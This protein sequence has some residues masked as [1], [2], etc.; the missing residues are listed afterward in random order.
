[1]NERTDEYLTEQGESNLSIEKK[2]N[3]TVQEAVEYSGIGRN[4][5]Y[6]LLKNPDCIFRLC[7]G[8]K[9]LVKRKQFEKYLETANA[10]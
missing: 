7:V 8:R 9:I 5:L 6:E 4:K 2:F 10:I 1:M 3:L